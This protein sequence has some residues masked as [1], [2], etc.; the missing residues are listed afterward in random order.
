MADNVHTLRIGAGG[1]EKGAISWTTTEQARTYEERIRRLSEQVSAGL[2]GSKAATQSCRAL[3]NHMIGSTA[4]KRLVFAHGGAYSLVRRLV[5]ASGDIAKGKAGASLDAWA[6]EAC[7]CLGSLCL[8]LPAAAQDCARQ[9]LAPALAALVSARDGHAQRVGLAGLR[10]LG[11]LLEATPAFD[12]SELWKENSSRAA[13]GTCSG[14]FGL[15]AILASVEKRYA[16]HDPRLSAAVRVLAAAAP[17][18][19][20]NPKVCLHLIDAM[21][22]MLVASENGGRLNPKITLNALIGLENVASVSRAA[23]AALRK[24]DLKNGASK[25]HSVALF[26]KGSSP[27]V[28]LRACGVI[29]NAC[30]PGASGAHSESF[31]RA[32]GRTLV[33]L[34]RGAGR[35]VGDERDLVVD[36]APTLLARLVD[37][38]RRAVGFAVA[39][40]EHLHL[41]RTALPNVDQG[42]VRSSVG[43]GEGGWKLLKALCARGD[44]TEVQVKEALLSNDTLKIVVSC[45]C[46]PRPCVQDAARHCLDSVR[47]S[48]HFM[49]HEDIAEPLISALNQSVG[50]PPAPPRIQASILCALCNLFLYSERAKRAAVGSVRPGQSD[51]RGIGGK[52]GDCDKLKGS[53]EGTD[54]DASSD[55]DCGRCAVESGRPGAA[56]RG[57]L[58]TLMLLTGSKVEDIRLTAVWALKNIAFKADD[59]IKNA[60]AARIGLGF[61]GKL[62]SGNNGVATRVQCLQLLRALLYRCTSLLDLLPDS[63]PRLL[64]EMITIITNKGAPMQPDVPPS[65]LKNALYAIGALAKHPTGLA[66]AAECPTLLQRVPLLVGHRDQTVAA[67][68]VCC[69]ARLVRPRSVSRRRNRDGSGAPR[70]LQS[71]AREAVRAALREHGLMKHLNEFSGDAKSGAA[72]S[73][74]DIGCVSTRISVVE[75]QEFATEAVRW[76]RYDSEKDE[77]QCASAA[78]CDESASAAKKCRI[79]GQS[80]DMRVVDTGAG[81]AAAR[82]ADTD[83]DQWAAGIGQGED[84]PSQFAGDADMEGRR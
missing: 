81:A 49:T 83:D 26:L 18:A 59:D 22:R 48:A 42:S 70:A 29:I 82:A 45:L 43:G 47:K 72:S 21:W 12:H 84:G 9:G 57:C 37:R 79:D 40:I 64:S 63:T 65:L 13:H 78:G 20:N 44:M 10:A 76:L 75:A 67:A 53:S 23:A 8:S 17:A 27:V 31:S 50:D 30:Q 32:A 25:L 35:L 52:G 1:V 66:A 54:D 6:C 62:L 24:N 58:D 3:K 39:A 69:A 33:R 34:I 73:T 4:C 55:I 41:S 46:D 19:G 60:V 61:F 2:A 80:C 77:K 7:A 71:R 5:T 28:R 11:Q 38:D 15:S 68:A 16:S 51:S 56:A 36:H 14:Y 74:Q